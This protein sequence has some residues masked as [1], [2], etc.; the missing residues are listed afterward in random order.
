MITQAITTRGKWNGRPIALTTA[1]R[2][3][4]TINEITLAR[5]PIIDLIS[6]VAADFDLESDITNG[7]I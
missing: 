6:E 2:F 1:G 5:Y 7:D 3:T 4:W